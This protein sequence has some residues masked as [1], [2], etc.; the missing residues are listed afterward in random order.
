MD[1]IRLKTR[2]YEVKMYLTQTHRLVDSLDSQKGVFLKGFENYA[3]S[4]GSDKD[5]MQ[6]PDNFPF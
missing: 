2:S 1:S 5:T 4:I 6:D 3:D